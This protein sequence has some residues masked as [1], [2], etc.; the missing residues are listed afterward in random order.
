MK[1]IIILCSLVSVMNMISYDARP[2]AAGNYS[3]NVLLLEAELQKTDREANKNR[4]IEH[5]AEA[6]LLATEEGREYKQ[7][8]RDKSDCLQA[9]KFDFDDVMCEKYKEVQKAALARIVQMPEYKEQYL[10]RIT[11]RDY[12]AAK[13]DSLSRARGFVIHQS[14]RFDSE[15]EA[16]LAGIKSNSHV[17]DEIG[18]P[19]VSYL[20]WT[21]DYNKTQDEVQK[22]LY[23]FVYGLMALK[24]ERVI[25]AMERLMNN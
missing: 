7:A 4:V 23:G 15:E 8:E 18:K 6:Q 13:A 2:L 1:K 22:E 19:S 25:T 11:L 16:M 10:P 21:N 12:Y 24:E 20:D 14:H 17:S 9:N 5:Q 3:E